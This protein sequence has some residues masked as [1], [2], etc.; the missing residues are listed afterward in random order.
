VEK[1]RPPSFYGAPDD[2]DSALFVELVLKDGS[3]PFSSLFLPAAG[4]PAK[5]AGAGRRPLGGSLTIN[6]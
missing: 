3:F 5:P 2:W 1:D 6:T 4:T